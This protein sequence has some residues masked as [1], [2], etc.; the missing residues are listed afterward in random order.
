MEIGFG[1]GK[2]L[3]EN[4]NGDSYLKTKE[5]TVSSN[6]SYRIGIC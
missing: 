3:K 4:V 2:I 5:W 6:V 1:T